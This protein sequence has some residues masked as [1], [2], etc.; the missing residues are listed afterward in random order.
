MPVAIASDAAFH[1]RYPEAG[2]LLEAV[3]L[4][5][6]SSSPLADEPLP[7]GCRAVLLPGGYPELHAAQL[8]ASRRSLGGLARA[9]AAGLPLVASNWLSDGFARSITLQ[10]AGKPAM[11]LADFLRGNAV[12]AG[13]CL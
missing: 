12:E 2:E 6:L 8:A 10:R 3:G 7:A 13:V 5:P 4:E 11:A 1:F 9:A